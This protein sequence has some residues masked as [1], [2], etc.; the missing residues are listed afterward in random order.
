LADPHYEHLFSP[1]TIGKVHLKDRMARTAAQTSLFDSGDR[2]FGP[3]AKAFCDEPGL[4]PDAT[5]A[6]WKILNAI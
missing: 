5:A 1:M 4:I 6:G 3:L 2:R